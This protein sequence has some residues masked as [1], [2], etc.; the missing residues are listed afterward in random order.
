MRMRPALSVLG[1]AVLLALTAVAVPAAAA[2]TTITVWGWDYQKKVVDGLLPDFYKLHPDIK[3]EWK[4]MQPQQ[5]RQNM[6]LALSSGAGAPDVFA[7]ESAWVGQLIAVGGIWDITDKVQALK[8][9]FNAYKWQ[10]VSLDGRIY[11]M[12]WDSGPVA[13]YYR[14][15]VLQESGLPT[16]PQ[17]VADTFSTWDRY[18]ELAGKIHSATKAYMFAH[19]KANNDARDWEKLAWQAGA[20]YF[21]AAGRVILDRRPENTRVLEFLA[22]F[23][24]DNMAQDAQPWTPAWYAGFADGSVAT[25]F[26]AVWMG[27]FLKTWVAPKAEGKWGVA[28]LPAW[29]QGG[30]RTS[31]D[32]GS[33]LLI[34][35]Q[36][37]H[38]EAAWAFVSFVTANRDAQVK[39][40]E[41]MDSFPSLESAYS[42]PIAREPDPYFAGQPYRLVFVELAKQIPTWYYTKDYPEA[43]S[44]LAAEIVNVALGKKTPEQAIKDAATQIRK[45]TGR[46]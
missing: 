20:G 19:A 14:R 45:R 24:K 39:A 29:T 5:V 33:N 17:A 35:A 21:D 27:G 7:A 13:L 22:R 36:S 28:P 9:Q 38:K 30:V 25:H 43:N 2:P 8:D 31:N 46:Q 15:D 6:L 10:D 44:I 4:V 11:G 26:G 40:W 12:P 16:D 41:S 3:V 37:K 42:A 1:M 32:G 18:Y 23:W 34:P